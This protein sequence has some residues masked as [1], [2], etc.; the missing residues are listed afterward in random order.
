MI[1]LPPRLP[2]IAVTSQS[3]VR[4]ADI[5]HKLPKRPTPAAVIFDFD[6][7]VA[8]RTEEQ[9]YRLPETQGEIKKLKNIAQKIDLAHELY[10]LKYLRHLILQEILLKMSKSIEPGPFLTM[11]KDLDDHNI[12]Y[13]ILT[14]RSG[15]AAITRLIQFLKIHQLRPQECFCVG[16]VAKGR[17][18]QLVRAAVGAGTI[19]YIDDSERHVANSFR[20]ID[21]ETLT[22]HVKWDVS[23]VLE[24][25]KEL[26]QS[27]MT[28]ADK[29]IIPAS[30]R[31][32]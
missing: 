10:D 9:I 28:W 2:S 24:N 29:F 22:L 8:H 32:A 6:G 5:R 31:A 21:P 1:R 3:H 11:A 26:Y 12:P 13:F 4:L 18:I 17:Q 20:Q 19:M 30:D 7:V 25:A 14:A 27:C 16:R 15:I 23:N